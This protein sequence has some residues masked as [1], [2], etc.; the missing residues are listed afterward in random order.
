MFVLDITKANE[1][2]MVTL[3]NSWEVQPTVATDV[4]TG[5]LRYES[6]YVVVG[7]AL[8]VVSGGRT[9]DESIAAIADQ[10]IVYNV[11]SNSWQKYPNY[12]EAPYGNRQM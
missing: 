5:Q 12:M 3:A 4:N 6:Q 8:L 2:S 9:D 1:A 7:G 11:T 10:T